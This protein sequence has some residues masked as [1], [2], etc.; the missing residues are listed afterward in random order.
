MDHRRSSAVRIERVMTDIGPATK[1]LA[2]GLRRAGHAAV[3]HPAVHSQGQ[4][5]VE[6]FVQT[7]LREWAYARPYESSPGR[8]AAL[9]P[10]IDGCNWHRPYLALNHQP[11]MGHIASVNELLRLHT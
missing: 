4:R 6:R 10:F 9:Q 1:R 3:P 8:Q 5:Q 2:C 7:S 11:P